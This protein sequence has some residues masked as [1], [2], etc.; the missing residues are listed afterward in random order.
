MSKSIIFFGE[1]QIKVSVRK[2]RNSIRL[3]LRISSTTEN[4]ILTAPLT[5]KYDVLLNFLESKENWIRD[6]LRKV[7]ERNINVGAG[8]YVPVFGSDRLI[9]I[10]SELP[11]V[12]LDNK[13]IFVPSKISKPNLVVKNYLKNLAEEELTNTA[14]LYCDKLGVS[15]S[16]IKLR[17]PRSR[18]GSCSFNGNLMFSWRIIM[19]PKN[20]IRYLVA[21]EVTHLQH[22]NHSKDFWTTV[23]FLF[24]P[25]ENERKWLRTEGTKLHFYKF[26]G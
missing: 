3:S 18:W 20:I 1:P 19:A 4:V 17:D 8:E 6:K 16:K 7:S 11:H 21:H 22:F 25:Y 9:E 24:G 13:N 5:T 26:K 10:C 2:V 14:N 12:V 23:L 15:Y